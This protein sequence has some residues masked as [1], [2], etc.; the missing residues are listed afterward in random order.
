MKVIDKVLKQ[1]LAAQ[2][3]RAHHFWLGG[4][5]WAGSVLLGWG[6]L[7]SGLQG[8]LGTVWPSGLA[9]AAV[10]G[11]LVAC[12]LS[13]F[14]VGCRSASFSLQL[15]SRLIFQPYP[16]SFILSEL[17]PVVYPST[18]AQPRSEW[19]VILINF[20][21]SAI[22]FLPWAMCSFTLLSFFSLQ[23]RRSS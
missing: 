12:D 23:L 10:A 5:N 6:L 20:C 9:G 8:C 11:S 2:V 3:A 22:N 4:L 18:T 17:S 16:I 13:T 14:Y 1:D 7:G 19:L 21:L 15:S